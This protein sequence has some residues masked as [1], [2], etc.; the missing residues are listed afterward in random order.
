[1]YQDT[2]AAIATPLGVGALGVVRLSGSG[3]ESIVAGLFTRPLQ[4]HRAV[5]G[6]L[7]DPETGSRVDEVMAL[8][9]SAPRSYTREDMVE[10]TCHGG[11]LVV[12]TVL[13]LLLRQ[14]ARLADPGEFTL[15]AFLNGRLDL[16]Q[17]ESVLDVIISKTP[18]GLRLA[19]DGLSGALSERVRALRGSL[20]EPLAYLTALVDFPED[21][22]G[23]ID[24]APAM[25]Q[26]LNGIEA[27]VATAGQGIIYRDGVRTAIIGRPNAGKSSLLNRL[28]GRDRA[29]VASVPGTT[30]DTLE[31]VANLRDIPFVFVDTAGIGDTVDQI[32]RMGIERSR[33]TADTADV[34]LFVVDLSRG[35][36]TQDSELARE[37]AG[38]RVF[39]VGNKADLPP[40]PWAV[41]SEGESQELALPA[42]AAG[43]PGQRVSALTGDGIDELAGSLRRFVLG[44]AVFDGS[45][46]VVCNV[47]HRSALERAAGHVRD[48]L[49]A[50]HD[51][52][53][54]DF[55]TIDLT[56]AV[57]ALGDITGEAAQPD[58][59]DAIFS[60]FCIGK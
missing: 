50:H 42:G 13:G 29:I 47:R 30:R 41:P 58:L 19:V 6:H 7:T 14:G 44:A 57:E 15:R 52:L 24:V 37:L 20:L 9:L 43:W 33:A 40:A 18:A 10:V 48:A 34:V 23:T 5:Y 22:V 1:M 21:E 54:A 36:D 60:K 53:P 56:S 11:P 59:L 38:R 32:E 27:L 2:I 28:L 39:V 4:D 45:E 35:W 46:P 16:A 12:Q 3:S 49:R 26:A 25:E 51:R 8:L 17:A 31:E 55:I